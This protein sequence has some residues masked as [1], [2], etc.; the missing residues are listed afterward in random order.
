MTDKRSDRGSA[1]DAGEPVVT[2]SESEHARPSGHANAA[3]ATADMQA[4]LGQQLRA[5]YDDIAKQPVPDRF[6][7]LMEQLDRKAGK[8]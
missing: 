5:V 4:L 7:E 2:G 3:N 1:T 6:I 8:R